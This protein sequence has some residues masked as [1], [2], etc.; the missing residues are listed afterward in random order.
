MAWLAADAFG[1]RLGANPIE[2]ITHRTGDWTIRF[3]LATLAV[4]PLRQLTGWNWLIKYRRT[5]GLI[6]F[7]YVCVHFLT[8]V[9]LDQG[10]A[11][12]YVGDDIAKR[13]YIT[14]GFTAFLL[15]IPLA[16]TST[17]GWVRRLG[18]RRWNALHRLI[19]ISAALGVLHYLW[20]VKGDQLTPVYYGGV[21]VLL[22]ALR[23]RRGA[24]R[25][26]QQRVDLLPD[27]SR[28]AQIGGEPLHRPDA[29]VQS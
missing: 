15:L 17:Q 18:G 10:F 1:D 26:V 23:I 4:T 29:R 11:L 20:L 2:E 9:G 13:P 5:I 22:L 12:A 24:P 6:A 27:A 28:G 21:L 8:Y 25:R 3:L 19:Y 7:S 16:I 14:V